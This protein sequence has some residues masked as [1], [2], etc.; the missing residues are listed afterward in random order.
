MQLRALDYMTLAVIEYMRDG[1]R[2][3]EEKEKT[4]PQKNYNTAG[5]I[6]KGQDK[7]GTDIFFFC[8]GSRAV[9]KAI[10]QRN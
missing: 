5:Q 3:E 8:S 9:I 7:R 2:A 4:R 1:E 10:L 6:I